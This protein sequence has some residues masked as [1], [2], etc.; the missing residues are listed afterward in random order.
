VRLAP[1]WLA[2][3]LAALVASCGG[4][5]PAFGGPAP[6]RYD[7]SKLEATLAEIEKPGLVL[8]E[9]NLRRDGVVDGD[10]IKVEGLDTSLRLVCM[11][12]EEKF[13]RKEERRQYDMGWD[14][15]QK[16]MRGD[17]PMPAKYATPMGE[18]ASA[19]AKQWFEHVKVVR[20]ER[21][22]PK[23]MRDAYG[24]FLVYVFAEKDGTWINYNVEAV[25]A[26]MSPYFM[27][28]GYSRRFHDEF[29]QAEK[30]AR[31]AGVGIWDPSKEHYPDYDERGRWW[32]IRANFIQ[33]FEDEAGDKPNY[34][35][36]GHW[37]SL[38]RL[39]EHLGKPV[40]ILATIGSV[41]LSDTGPHKVI[42]SRRRGSDFPLIYFDKDLF[43]SSQV[44]RWKGEFVRVQ[45]TVNKY[46]D[47]WRKKHELQIVIDLASQVQG[48]I[49]PWF[50]EYGK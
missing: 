34:I 29:V 15:Y 39:E 42:L 44:A 18:E 27:K 37:D 23:D 10:T 31:A 33:Q 38:T 19:W 13:W 35:T 41:R 30:D 25:R 46:Y 20:L 4:A 21:D 50:E 43:G 32:Q 24:R 12:T 8:G 49:L 48:P 9:F 36:L 22:H 17:R 11:D 5:E 47:K 16:T 3:W 6:R 28:Y 7:R 45:G 40:E 14:F 26:G 1:P 2:V